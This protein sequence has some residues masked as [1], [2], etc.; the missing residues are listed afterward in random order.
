MIQTVIQ[1]QV[2]T[3]KSTSEKAAQLKEAALKFLTGA[4]VILKEE[5]NQIK[6]KEKK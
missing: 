5:K 1:N 2:E 4:S 3:I 6:E